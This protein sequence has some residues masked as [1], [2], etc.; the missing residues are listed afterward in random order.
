[1]LGQQKIIYLKDKTIKRHRAK[2]HVNWVRERA[3]PKCKFEIDKMEWPMNEKGI[4]DG[5]GMETDLCTRFEYKMC[6]NS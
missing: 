6:Y 3:F 5:N 4:N 1:M 2:L